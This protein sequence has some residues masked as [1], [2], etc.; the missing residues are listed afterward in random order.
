MDK[1]VLGPRVH[2]EH[3]WPPAEASFRQRLEGTHGNAWTFF[4]L[5]PLV[6]SGSQVIGEEADQKENNA[7]KRGKEI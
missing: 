6:S 7:R 4:L 5:E 3:R 1:H 2:D